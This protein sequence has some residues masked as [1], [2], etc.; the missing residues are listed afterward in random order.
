V[1]LLITDSNDFCVHH[2]LIHLLNL[3]T[4]LIELPSGLRENPLPLL[5]ILLLAFIQRDV[6]P[7]LGLDL[8]HPPLLC[9]RRSELLLT[10]FLVYPLLLELFLLGQDN[11]FILKE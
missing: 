9:L 1:G 6:L 3:I 10:L 8:E 4:L 11:S 2:H 5:P 7:L